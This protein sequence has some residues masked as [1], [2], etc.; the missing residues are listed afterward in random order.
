MSSQEFKDWESASKI[1]P[2]IL[3]LLQKKYDRPDVPQ[4]IP[5]M[6]QRHLSVIYAAFIGVS[7]SV[8]VILLGMI[9]CTDVELIL[10]HCCRNLVVFCV[11]GFMI[12]FI[13]EMCMRDS[14]KSMIREMLQ[15]TDE[16]REG[17]TNGTS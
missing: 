4:E 2:L 14:A 12:G 11:I 5:S 7:A 16:L 3:R 10:V 9:R 1:D 15:R 13:A 8:L 17:Q 6:K